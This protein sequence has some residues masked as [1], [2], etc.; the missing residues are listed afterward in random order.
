M[1]KDKVTPFVGVWIEISN[2]NFS[3]IFAPSLPSWECGLKLLGNCANH[4]TMLSL[5][6]WE[7]GLKYLLILKYYIPYSSLPSW[8]C[9][10]KYTC[11]ECQLYALYVTPFVGVW[12]EIV[13]RL[14]L[15]T[16]NS[17]LPSWECGLKCPPYTE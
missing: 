6:S 16:N 15:C 3:R 10:L 8:E 9:G 11:G 5:P 12:I 2:P 7:C 13:S 4:V 1:L 14:P 17:S